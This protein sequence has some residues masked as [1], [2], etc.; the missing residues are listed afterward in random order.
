MALFSIRKIG[1]RYY[2][3]LIISLKSCHK[4]CWLR[5][6]KLFLLVVLTLGSMLPRTSHLKLADPLFVFAMQKISYS[7]ALGPDGVPAY[8]RTAFAEELAVPV[9]SIWRSSL[10]AAASD[11]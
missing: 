10:D 5:P 9:N 11:A 6:G 8:I 7:S 2:F 1:N 4:K 3:R